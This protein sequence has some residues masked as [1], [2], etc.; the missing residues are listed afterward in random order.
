M[1]HPIRSATRLGV[2]IALLTTVQGFAA[3]DGAKSPDSLWTYHAVEPAKPKADLKDWIR[4]DGAAVFTLDTEQLRKVLADAPREFTPK[5]SNPVIFSLPT[6]D[7]DYMRFEAIESPIWEPGFELTMPDTM[8]YMGQ[9]L[10]DP[11]AHIRFDWTPAGFHASVLSADGAWFVD[12][13]WQGD[14]TTYSAYYKRDFRANANDFKCLVEAS[15]ELTETTPSADKIVNGATLRSYRLACAATVEYTAFHGGTAALGQAAIVT[16]INRVNQVYEA[17]V[18]LRMNLVAN[19]I[20]L[21]YVTAPDPYTNNSGPTMLGENQTNVNTVIGTAN[22]DIGHVFSTGGGGI[23]QLNSP[24]TANKAQG[25]TGSPSPTGDPFWIDYVAHEMGHQWGGNHTFNG[26]GGNCSGANRNA[27]TAYEIGSGSTIQAYAGICPPDDLQSN[28][29]AYFHSLSLDEIVANITSGS[30]S[31]CDVPTATGN[32]PPTVNAGADYTIPIG[33]PFTVTA[34]GSDANG[35]TLT[36]CW[37][38][39]DLGAAQA[40]SAADN[41]TSPIFRSYNPTTSPS[42]TFPRLSDIITNTTTNFEKYPAQNRTLDLRVVARDNRAG[43]GGIGSDDMV[44]DVTTSAGPFAVT[45]PNTAVTWNT[46]PQNVTWVTANTT[47]APVNTANVNILLSTDGGLTFPTI[48][49]ANTP[50]DGSQSVALPTVNSTQCRIKV[51]AAGNIYWDMSNTNFTINYAGGAAVVT[52]V[53]SPSLDG[54]YITGTIPIQ[55]TFNSA[56]Q[57]S[58]APL[59]ALNTSP[60][61]NATYSSGTGTSTLTFNYNITAGD[62]VTDLDYANNTALTLN[63]GTIRDSA[64]NTIDAL[65]SLATPGNT[66]SLGF[67]KNIAIGASLSVADASLVEGNTGTSNMVFTVTLAPANPGPG[68]VTVDYSLTGVSATGGTDFNATGGTV[69]FTTGQSTRPINVPINGDTALEPNETFTL[70]L[71]NSSGPTIAQATATG[72][73]T[74]D[75]YPNRFYGVSMES[76]AAAENEGFLLFDPSNP[77]PTAGYFINPDMVAQANAGTVLLGGDFAGTDRSVFYTM[78]RTTVGG[79]ETLYRIDASNG[80][81]LSTSTVA[82]PNPGTGGQYYVGMKWD[83]ANSRMVV[84]TMD[85][86]GTPANRRCRLSSVTNL[87]S[88]AASLVQIA[89]SQTNVPSTTDFFLGFAFPST[90]TTGYVLRSPAAGGTGAKTLMTVNTGTGAMGTVG[91]VTVGGS[92]TALE[93]YYTDLAFDALDNSLYLSAYAATTFLNN[94][95]R[96]G[97]VG[98]PGVAATL[99]TNMDALTPSNYA[100]I[101]GFTFARLPAGTAQLSVADAAAITEGNSGT[102]NVTFAVTKTGA[103]VAAVTVDWAISGIN[104]TDTASALT[105]SLNF[106]ISGSNATQNVVIAVAGDTTWETNEP[107]AISLSNNSVNSV[108]TDGAGLSQVNNDDAPVANHAFGYDQS[109]DGLFLFDPTSIAST[110]SRSS[111]AILTNSIE[112]GTFVGTDTTTF[113]ALD[114]TASTLRRVNTTTGVVTSSTA[115]TGF[116][117]GQDQV[118][119]IAWDQVAGVTRVM[120]RNSGTGAVRLNTINT[121]TAV[122]TPTGADLTGIPANTILLSLASDPNTGTLY[123]LAIGGV[124]FTD[125]LCSINTGTSV[126]AQIGSG[127]GFDVTGTY[128]TDMAFRPSTGVL[129]WTGFSGTDFQNL[130]TINTATGVATSV[131]VIETARNVF[132]GS[133]LGFVPGVSAPTISLTSVAGDPVNGA[134]TVNATL[135]AAPDGGTFTSADV[136]PTNAT[137]SGFGGAGTAWSWTLTPTAQGLFSCVVNASTFTV[138]ATGNTASNTL[139]RTFDSVGPTISLASAAGDPVNGAITVTATLSEAPAAGTFTTGDV[140]PT[141]ATVSGFAGAGT[142]WSWT[143]TPT[144]QGL[145][146]CIVNAA[147]F[148]DATSNPNTASNSLS[149]TFDSVGPTISLATAAG[150]PVNGAITV[151]ATLSEAPAGGS[152]TAGDVTPTNATVSGFAGAGTSWSWTL[153]PTAQGLFSCIVNASTFTDA[154]LNPNSVSNSLSRTFDSVAPTISLASAA[155]DPVNGAITVTATLSEAPAGGSFTSGDVTPTNATVSGFAGAG[156]SWSWTLTPTAQGLFSCIVNASQFNDGV[157]NNTASNTLSRTFDSVGPTISLASAAGDP[158]NGAITV[159]ATLSEAPAGG[160]FTSADVTPTNATVSGFGGAGTAWS[161]TLTPTAQGAFSCI[162]NAATFTDAATNPNTVSNSL[163]RTFDSVGPTISLASVAGDPVNGAITVTATLSEAPAAGTFTSVDVTPTNATVSGF[164]G[165]GTSWS[166]TLTPTAQGLF[167]CIVNAA[168]FTDAATNPNTVSNTL[169]RT[170]DSAG[171]TISLASAAGDPVNGAITVTATL[172]EAPAGGTFTSGDVTPTNATV[173]GFA[174]AGTSWSWT[175]TPTAQGLFSCVVNA[176]TFTDATSNPNTASNSLSRTFDSVGPT[177]SLASA[178]GDPV[179]GAITVTATLSEAPAGGT[180]TSGDVTPTNAT[181]S[182]FAGA[183]TSWSWTLTPTAQGLFSCVVNAATFTDATSNPNTASNTLSRTFDSAGPTISLASAAGDPVNGA[184]TVTATLSEAPAGGTFTSGDVTP[185]NA[186]V[187]GFAGAGTSWSWTLTPTA[188]G[189]F[190]CV[191]NAATFTDATANTNTASNTLSRTF[192]SVG[193]TISL[194]SAASDPVNGAI[195]VNATLSEAPAGGS[196]TSGDVTPTNA[197]VSGFAGAGTSWSWTLTPTAQGLFSCVVNAST[198]TDAT[199]N[200]NTASNSLSR[201]FDSVQPGVSM[202]SIASDPT[203]TSPIPVTVTFTEPV[204]GFVSGDIVPGN[205]TVG[206]F[207][208]TGANYSFNLF[209]LGAGTV[210]ADI[211]AGVAQDGAGNLNT[212]SAQ[213]SRLYNNV[214]PTVAMTSPFPD[215]TNASPIPVTVTFSASVSGFVAGDIT[216]TN[217]SVGAFAGSGAVYTFDLTPSGQGLVSADIAAGVAIDGATNPNEAAPTFSRVYD[218]VQPTI[219]LASAAGDPVNGAITV[220]ATLSETPSSGSFISTDVTPTNATVSGFAGAGT[221][222]SW[223]LTPIGQG[224][225]SCVVNAGQFNDG[226]NN[227]SA[228]NV[229][230]R[231]FDSVVPTISLASAATDPVNAAITVTATLSEAPA[232]GS[233]TSADVTPTNATVSGFAGAGTSWSWTLT[234]TAQGLF[235]CVVNA[236]TFTDAALNNNTASNSLS[237]TFDSVVPTISLAS[238]A[239]DPVNAA[240]TVTATLSEAPATG[241]F[242]SADV[243]VTNATV[244]GF[245]GGGTSWSWTLTPTAQG[246]FSCIVNANR[247]TDDAA[248]TNTASNSISRTF[249]SVVPTISLASAATDPVNAAITVT[250]TLSEAPATGTFTSA[251]VTPTNATVSGFAGAGTSWS[252]TLTPT[253]QGLFSCVVNASTFTDAALNNNTASNSLSRTFDSVVPTISLASAAGDPVNAA[254]TVTA[255]L[256]EAPAT[257]TFTSADVTPTNATVSGFAGAGTSWSWTLTPTAQGLFSCVVNASTFTDAALNNNTASNS[258]SRT[259]DSVVPTISLASAAGDPVGGAITVTATLSETPAAGS[260]TS[261]DV[262]PTNATVSG[263]AGA[264]TSWSWTLTPSA[265]GL[266]SCV[267]NAS[268]FTDAALNNN[269]ASNTLS[270]TFDTVSPSITLA[271]AASDPVNGAITVTA[272]L[273]DAPAGGSFT[274]ADVTPTNATVSGFAGAGTSWSWTLTPTA[275]GLFSCIVNA[276]TFD[277]GINS[278]TA[279]NSLSRTFDSVAPSAT[280]SSIAPDPTNAAFTVNVLL[281][282][283]SSN[284]VAGDLTATNGA[285]SAF[286]GS[287]TSYSFTFTPSA[288]GLASVEIQAGAFT[289]AATN[290][291]TASNLLSRTFDSIAPTSSAT[292]VAD[293]TRVGTALSFNFTAADASALNTNLWVRAPGSGVFVDTGSTAAGTSGSLNYTATLGVNGLYEFAT[294]STDAAGNSEAAPVTA[295]TS[296]LL[297]TV[298]NGAFT[299]TTTAASELLVFPMTDTLDMTIQVNSATIGGQVTMSRATP[300]GG[301]PAGL[302]ASRLI[303]EFLTITEA[304]LGGSWS[305]DLTWNFDPTSD[306]LLVGALDTVFQFEGGSQI[307]TYPVTPAGN[308]LVVTG[309]VDFSEWYAGNNDTR[310]HDWMLFD[311]AE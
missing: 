152:F 277:D 278:N 5:A 146:S 46:S 49:L 243:A 179:N 151:T 82:L 98:T 105:G 78:T 210:T 4:S 224:S 16:A 92:A 3:E 175:L 248:N 7:G 300:L 47:N 205:A 215:P 66:G 169:S 59:L 2:F 118:L 122:L 242:T 253:A 65:L 163:S 149:R 256:S 189:L 293:P 212:A 18:A 269:T 13:Y 167:S 206:G 70:T 274:S 302:T 244:S 223:T 106:P 198:F 30:G 221:S 28:S 191:V 283:S 96:L 237:R 235:S 309:I 202:A 222:W 296:V 60:A 188:Q 150:N 218:S 196:F 140:T 267:V 97:A 266:F 279:S 240:I 288:Q 299:Q 103:N 236:S 199:L 42:R 306:D 81:T 226:I 159:N 80:Q 11:T 53:T 245:A 290:G 203:N 50:N 21:V 287:G 289:D 190:S 291:N 127:V 63:G 84:C 130:Y 180:F 56:V 214:N 20:N 124:G 107:I 220:T 170:F 108:I 192:D 10:D 113:Y 135:S 166:W 9:C 36:Y 298:A 141:N 55:V 134:I 71:S 129:Y 211:A 6:P 213:F 19:N 43:G 38:Q 232:A 246:L 208:G 160:T 254:I 184:I 219:S 229:L 23:A 164:A 91:S 133:A 104:A 131:E 26:T 101:S 241:T 178:A 209:P 156:T 260:F 44:I 145:F 54:T 176:A 32:T 144:A 158:V 52:N 270:R 64:T 77:G 307:N 154:T 204:T 284:F 194:A 308:S 95:Y 132:Q 68:N 216:P 257:G 8:T 195:T 157:N 268:T 247:F 87:A 182:G 73:I 34:S 24:C 153:T 282:E 187:S 174:G 217:G 94:L 265:Q 1:K 117:A 136:T 27:A 143:L 62:F 255:T 86:T 79:T 69:T 295:D 72:T 111:E 177:I 301:A 125:S 51:E 294:R 123:T 93:T 227:N 310:V 109:N 286:A 17:E 305:A 112:G 148:T 261:A 161:W 297:N 292:A 57:V 207:A 259:F 128:F 74:N 280:L 155:G 29:D 121:T 200:P 197:T 186:T 304:G 239:T 15:G 271:S 35:D 110:F 171:P 225:F 238:A 120:S 193:P 58:G 181:V 76:S 264:G 126:V 262:T 165:A 263:F 168:T 162:V 172:S 230:S 25:V 39:R 234:P 115:I 252:W 251:D 303:N 258:L 137:V 14:T 33:T 12:P 276:G 281:G 173:S 89:E 37:E 138:S 183:G 275:Q 311:I 185:T 272:T 90:G 31:T 228:S 250:A 99:I 100:T 142:S 40:L 45:T 61:R 85:T 75:D 102:Q 273:S 285:V 114:F 147:T 41:G 48:L 22:Y 67:N 201:T 249:D 88:G 116:A 119:G 233:F 83:T 231:T 139:S